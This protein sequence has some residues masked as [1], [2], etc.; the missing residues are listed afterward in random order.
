MPPSASRCWVHRSRRRIPRLADLRARAAA[1]ETVA[2]TSL[3]FMYANGEGVPEDDAE[4]VR[5]FRLA[6]EQGH[7]DAQTG[8]GWQYVNGFS[9]VLRDSLTGDVHGPDFV[10]IGTGA[11]LGPQAKPSGGFNVIL[12]HA[13]TLQDQKTGDMIGACGDERTGGCARSNGGSAC[14]PTSRS[15]S[16]LLS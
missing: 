6:A 1:G 2:Q 14:P 7:T 10:L 8:L 3:G 13:P 12:R 15:I 11:L 4:A 5:W 9:V 16:D